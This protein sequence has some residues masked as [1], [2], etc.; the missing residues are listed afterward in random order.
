M[1]LDIFFDRFDLVWFDL[2]RSGEVSI[3]LDRLRSV[4]VRFGNDGK[5]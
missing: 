2:E 3:G 1:G 5:L 4:L